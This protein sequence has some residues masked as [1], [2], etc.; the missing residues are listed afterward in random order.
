[1]VVFFVLSV[2]DQPA[3]NP[4][5]VSN[6]SMVDVDGTLSHATVLRL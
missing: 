1:M 2:Q 6:I 5:S 3:I 4:G